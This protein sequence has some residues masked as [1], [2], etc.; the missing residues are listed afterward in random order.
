[1][2]LD[3]VIGWSRGSCNGQ[4]GWV[5]HLLGCAVGLGGNI[6]VHLLG[7]VV[8]IGLGIA[9]GVIHLGWEVD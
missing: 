6:F 5:W 9:V 3:W 1:M 8:A 4:L 2:Q 7:W